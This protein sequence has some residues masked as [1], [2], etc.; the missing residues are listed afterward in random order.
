MDIDRDDLEKPKE[1]KDWAYARIKR[2][3]LTGKYI[4]GEQLRV[5]ELA[6][7][8]KISRTPV[9]EAL[10][11]LEH[12][13]L[14]NVAPRVGFFVKGITKQE[15]Q[16]LF[17]L[18]ELIEGYAAEKAAAHLEPKDLEGLEA[19][20]R[21][22][23]AAF[24]RGDLPG[25]LQ[26]EIKLHSSIQEHAQNKHLLRMIES[27]KDL[28]YRERVLSLSSTENVKES[29]REHERIVNAFRQRDGPLA[30]SMMREHISSV[31]NRLLALLDK[32]EQ[33]HD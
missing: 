29:L 21:E 15:M 8:M 3:V 32:M 16:E 30:V 6:E 2:D 1:L 7:T 19:L 33:H 26:S 13:S 23:Q 24:D 17:E 20:L 28:T 27:L 10:L 11:M 4:P 18:R 14:I 25:F 22:G 31:K 9:R 5:E 12:E